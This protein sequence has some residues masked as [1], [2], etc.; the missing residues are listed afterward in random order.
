M[1]CSECGIEKEV[2]QMFN[3]SHNN[4]PEDTIMTRFE[5]LLNEPHYEYI[6]EEC[7]LDRQE[8]QFD[9]K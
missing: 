7:L 3:P 4:F 1:K 6:C 8:K 5:W 9:Y 2:I